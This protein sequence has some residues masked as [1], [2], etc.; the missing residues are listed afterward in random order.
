[1]KVY[2]YSN[3]EQLLFVGDIHGN[4]SSFFRIIKNQLIYD[5]NDDIKNTHPL[6]LEENNDSK[7]SSIF[8]LI[9]K[10]Y[11]KNTFNNSLI[12]V[13]GDCG[14]G[15]NKFNYYIDNLT[16][17]NN[18]FNKTNTHIIFVRGNHDDPSYFTNELI[19]LSN[20]KTIPDYSVIKTKS[21]NTLCV[22]GATSVD[23]I[24]R[25]QQEFRLNKYSKS[26]THKLYWENEGIYL[27]EKI[28][29]ELKD[30]EISID[31]VVTHTSPSFA[32]PND[33]DSVLNWFKIDSKL[34][35]D[36]AT[37]RNTLSELYNLLIQKHKIQCWVYGHFHEN[38][39][40]LNKQN[41]LFI[42]LNDSFSIREPFVIREH[43]IFSKTLKKK[44]AN[45]DSFWN[46]KELFLK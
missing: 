26:K 35:D 42:G 39:Q 14:F 5:K 41:I 10:K 30:N 7:I 13:A 2:D 11:T 15:F 9:Q 43:M 32:L 45:S 46:D 18:L 37:E 36:L 8:Q 44:D 22:G 24:W 1:M 4:F 23:R 19:N 31:S 6:A 40:K 38:F 27:N 29:D 12:I 28:L 34:K 25:K 17:Y 33:K 16:K 21:H 3:I 20:M